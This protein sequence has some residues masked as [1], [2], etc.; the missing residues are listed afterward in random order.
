MKAL[1]GV[2]FAALVLTGCSTQAEPEMPTAEELAA[3]EKKQEELEAYAE[4]LRSG[5]DVDAVPSTSQDWFPEEFVEISSSVAV[6][7]VGE[8]KYDVVANKYCDSLYIEVNFLD[9][10]GIVLDWDNDL[11]RSLSPGE[12]AR[13]EF[14][15]YESGVKLLKF[16][17]AT[18]L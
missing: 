17:E 12:L 7:K 14:R 9:A 4:S 6:K 13:F 1:Y 5:I 15:S 2:A 11:Q 8:G 18:C 16:T 10:D 3:A